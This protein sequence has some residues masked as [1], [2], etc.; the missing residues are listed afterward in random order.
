[1]KFYVSTTL[2]LALFLPLM[3][4]AQEIGMQPQGSLEGNPDNLPVHEYELVLE[5]AMVNKTGKAVKGMTV[6]GGVPGPVLR[7]KE[8]EYAKITVT[9]KMEAKTS[10][11]WHGILLPNF[12]DGVPYSTLRDSAGEALLMSSRS[13]NPVLTGIIPTWRYRNK[14]VYG[15]IVIEPKKAHWIT[16]KTWC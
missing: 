14:R 7:F 16:I 4:M 5:D 10:V 2:L 11:H 9:N 3:G 15:S 12:Y 6:N 8:G 13:S 1:M